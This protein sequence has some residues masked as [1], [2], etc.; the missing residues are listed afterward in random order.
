MNLDS[1]TVSRRGV[2]IGATALA[3]IPLAAAAQTPVA[4]PV[5]GTQFIDR[6]GALFALVPA[7]SVAVTDASTL[8]FTWADLTTQFASVDLTRPVGDDLPDDFIA[9]TEA[10][11]LSHN[12]FRFALTPEWPETFGFE[13][14]A[15]D[16]VLVAGEPPNGIAVFAGVDTDRVRA[17][18]L[19]AGYLEVEQETGGS[20]LTFGDDLDPSTPV[21]R[22]GVGGM[23]QAVA[24]DGVAIFTRA[25][26]TI[27]QVTQVMAGMAPSMLESSGW[28]GL[29]ATFADD[30]VGMIALAPAALSPSGQA[31]VVVQAAFG[32]RAGATNVDLK[33]AMDR[34]ED[35]SD[36]ESIAEMSENRARVQVRIRYS[37]AAM[38]ASEAEAIPERWKTMDSALNG[39]P[40]TELMLVESAG[41]AESDSTVA[42]VDFRVKGPAGWWHNI[43]N[44]A[45]L[46]AFVPQE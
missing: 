26:E 31:G 1:F 7:E 39:R 44:N 46:G 18:L 43:I 32:V 4:T 30:T 25:E 24:R 38:A 19:A 34:G 36:V 9:D 33:P 17:T 8:P 28:P 23:N 45:D 14:L 2:L 37:D 11:P 29:M 12:A 10:L 42:A 41:V 21:G 16:Q 6:I 5:A 40:F 20:Y 27:Q 22:L 35:P 15:I 3:V 13:P